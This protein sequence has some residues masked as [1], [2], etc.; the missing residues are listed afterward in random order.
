MAF[1]LSLCVFLSPPTQQDIAPPVTHSGFTGQHLPFVGFTYTTDSCFSDR[2]SVNRAGLSDGSSQ[3][4]GGEEGVP[5]DQEGGL[6]VE[7]FERRIR[8][9]EQEKQELNRKL[10]GELGGGRGQRHT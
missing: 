10:Q 7:A 3:D 2:G 1:S 5:P 4:G 9:L 6:E 8:R